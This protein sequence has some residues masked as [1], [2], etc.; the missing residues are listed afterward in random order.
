MVV[1]CCHWC[2]HRKTQWERPAA[3]DTEGTLNMEISNSDHSGNSPE[4]SPL[5]NIDTTASTALTSSKPSEVK[6]KSY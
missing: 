2:V 1:L 4:T 6:I 3:N 5:Q